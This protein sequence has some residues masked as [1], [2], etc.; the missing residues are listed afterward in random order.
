MLQAQLLQNWQPS[1]H[2]GNCYVAAEL[3]LEMAEKPPAV[4]LESYL[5]L[6]FSVFALQL[7]AE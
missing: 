2:A 7:S 4:H 1:F 6:F 3:E 5:N